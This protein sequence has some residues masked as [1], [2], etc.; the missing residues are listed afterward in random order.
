MITKELVQ[1]V[2]AFLGED[3]LDFFQDVKE[4]HGRYDAHWA[5]HISNGQT[6]PHIVHLREGMQVRNAMRRHSDTTEWDDHMYDAMWVEVVRR[7]V[8][9]PPSGP[10]NIFD[11]IKQ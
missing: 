10:L 4:K 2:R 1:H 5:I 7:A 9:E 8:E 6:I 11:V 3:G